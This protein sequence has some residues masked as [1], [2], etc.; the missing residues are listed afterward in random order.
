MSIRKLYETYEN[1]I[2]ISRETLPRDSIGIL[3]VQEAEIKQ[4]YPE[5]MV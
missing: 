4:L 3:K 2:S 1:N 5:G